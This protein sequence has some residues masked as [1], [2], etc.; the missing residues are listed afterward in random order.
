MTQDELEALNALDNQ[1]RD[2]GGA[3]EEIDQSL[4]YAQ[5]DQ[6]L[7]AAD[8]EWEEGRYPFEI[9]DL[10][11]KKS[12]AKGFHYIELT[13]TA[14]AGLKKD[15]KMFD[16]VM[17]EGEK[18]TALARLVL[19]GKATDMY[20]PENK[21]FQGRYIDL[22]GKIVWADVVKTKDT[23]KGEEREKTGIGFRGYHHFSK[24]TLPEEGDVFAQEGEAMEAL[25]AAPPELPT[26]PEVLEQF[27]TPTEYVD[28]QIVN[29]GPF[30]DETE[31][32]ET[33][34]AE[35]VE[36]PAPVAAPVAAPRATASRPTIAAAPAAPRAAAAPR[37]TQPGTKPPF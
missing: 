11:L 30:V 32:L 18:P 22:V 13:L 26:E 25:E 6:D 29:E 35:E 36:E 17:L 3:S 10:K 15:R 21:R 37:P 24:F 7:S 4:L 19:L 12:K 1:V 31:E 16:R 34:P 2:T 5:Q 23:Y 33:L 14:I 20:D 8:D 27:E 9:T 28:E